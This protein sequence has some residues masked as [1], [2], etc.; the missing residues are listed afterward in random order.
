MYFPLELMVSR[1][2]FTSYGLP[3]G[4]S[5]PSSR[6]YRVS[7]VVASREKATIF[8]IPLRL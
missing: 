4:K 5:P 3:C 7:S 8:N 2:E 1:S 6:I